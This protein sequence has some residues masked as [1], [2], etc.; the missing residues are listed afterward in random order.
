M[1]PAVTNVKPQ[2]TAK[3]DAQDIFLDG[4]H[5][6]LAIY[7]TGGKSSVHTVPILCIPDRRAKY[8]L[9]PCQTHTSPGGY[10][11]GTPFCVSC[12]AAVQKCLDEAYADGVI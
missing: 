11:T 6:S 3:V 5:P 7:M 2:G 4:V 12:Q 1:T 8:G 9:D 10:C